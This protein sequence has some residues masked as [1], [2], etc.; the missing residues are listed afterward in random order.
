MLSPG[1]TTTSCVFT[2]LLL[3]LA[4]RTSTAHNHAEIKLLKLP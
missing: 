1:W 4:V 2:G 3:S